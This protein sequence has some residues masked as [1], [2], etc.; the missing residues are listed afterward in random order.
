MSWPLIIHCVP[1]VWAVLPGIVHT[2]SPHVF[3][4][5]V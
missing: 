3:T 5:T 4:V 1:N 2:S